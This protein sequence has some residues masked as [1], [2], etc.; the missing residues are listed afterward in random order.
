MTAPANRRPGRPRGP[1]MVRVEVALPPDMRKR[2]EQEADKI[3]CTVSALVR[4]VIT[5][6]G[7]GW[8]K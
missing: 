8:P 7:Y 1:Q 6:A 3:G 5:E 2:L 4:H